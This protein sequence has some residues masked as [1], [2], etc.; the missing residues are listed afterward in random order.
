MRAPTLLVAL[1]LFVLTPVLAGC[2]TPP[3]DVTSAST[4]SATAMGLSLGEPIEGITNAT[5]VSVGPDGLL[6]EAL[7]LLPVNRYTGHDAGEPTLGVT[8]DGV[9]FYAAATF[10]NEI[11]GQAAPLPRTDILR[12]ADAGASWDD[13]TPYLP[14]GLVRQH[15]ETGDPMVYVDP[16]TDRVFDIDQRA[17]VGCHT[18]TFSDDLGETWF[19]NSAPTCLTPPADHQTIVAAP[20]RL[21]T[22]AGYPNIVYVCWNIIATADCVRSLDGGMSFTPTGPTGAMGVKPDK[23]ADIILADDVSG[24]C[25][26]TVGHLAAAPDGTVYMPRRA[27]DEATVF[28]TRDDGTTWERVVVTDAVAPYHGGGVVGMDPAVSVDA[29]GNVHYIFQ[30]ADGHL[31]YLYSTDAGATWSSPRDIL[32]AG[33]SV[34]NLATITAG[35][36]GQVALAY[37]AST[38]PGGYEADEETMANASWDA[39]MTLISDATGA[40]ARTTTVRLNPAD[41]PLVRGS[42]GPGRCNNP[43]LVD[44]IDIVIDGEGRPWV[45]LVDNCIE[46]CA[47]A[48][49]TA[50]D[51]TGAAGF[52]ATLAAGPRLR[53]S[54]ALTPLA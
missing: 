44:F 32:P 30:G 50:D 47:G 9:I 41:D 20:P 1:S 36:A 22:T 28:I 43:G 31:Y 7:G 34:A 23:A 49:G 6:R 52:V 12:S 33:L 25:S 10:S 40:A 54:G 24:L 53:G 38:V 15:P 46:A 18:V 51:S 2:V 42:C 14:G 17:A 5:A 4:D 21:L 35:D 39:Y 16:S 27:C 13:V 37:V 19:A 26:S 29:E 3:E 45:A 48:D 11:L 8:S